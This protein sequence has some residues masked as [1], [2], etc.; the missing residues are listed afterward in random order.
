M[1]ISKVDGRFV[2][3]FEGLGPQIFPCTVQSSGGGMYFKLVFACIWSGLST[4]MLDQHRN[5]HC[6]HCSD[7]WIY[8]YCFCLVHYCGWFL[9]YI[10]DP[11]LIC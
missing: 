11:R 9:L 10:S 4:K 2:V 6:F 3:T 1:T 5:I 7:S 8:I